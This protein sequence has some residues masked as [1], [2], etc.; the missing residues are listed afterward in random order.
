MA[1]ALLFK[2]CIKHI[3]NLSRLSKFPILI[4]NRTYEVEN[5]LQLSQNVVYILYIEKFLW[6]RKLPLYKSKKTVV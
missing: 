2:P 6:F 4:S 3:L 1:A 5:L